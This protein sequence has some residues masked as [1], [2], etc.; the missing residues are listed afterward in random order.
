[1]ELMISRNVRNYRECNSLSIK[2]TS[3]KIKINYKMAQNIISCNRNNIRLE[4]V[5]NIA[6]S[7][8]ISIDDLLFKNIFKN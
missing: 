8:N 6:R 7:L 3:E 4:A 1:M 2:E 5:Y